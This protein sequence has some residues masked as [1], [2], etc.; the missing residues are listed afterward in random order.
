MQP[1]SYARHKTRPGGWWTSCPLATHVF[2][3]YELILYWSSWT[4]DNRSFDVMH[5]FHLQRRISA[6][7]CSFYLISWVCNINMPWIPKKSAVGFWITDMVVPWKESF[8]VWELGLSSR[9]STYAVV[10]T[11]VFSCTGQTTLSLSCNRQ[12]VSHVC[13]CQYHPVIRDWETKAVLNDDQLVLSDMSICHQGQVSSKRSF[14]LFLCILALLFLLCNMIWQIFLQKLAVENQDH[15]DQLCLSRAWHCLWVQ[16]V[17]SAIA[18]YILF[19][20]NESLARSVSEQFGQR[21]LVWLHCCHVQ[22]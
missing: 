2:E 18:C 12:S 10:K 13:R 20:L 5:C 3:Q 16:N 1:I 21:N 15:I 7:D 9:F 11:R 14:P 4:T 22:I 8:I 19:P 6:W 17:I